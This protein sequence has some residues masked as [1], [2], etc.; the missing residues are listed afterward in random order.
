MSFL[1]N[2]FKLALS[3]GTIVLV[4]ALHKARCVHVIARFQAF[5]SPNLEFWNSN[6]NAKNFRVLER[7]SFKFDPSKARRARNRAKANP[8]NKNDS[9]VT[10]VKDLANLSFEPTSQPGDNLGFELQ[11][12]MAKALNVPIPRR[13]PPPAA[14]GSLEYDAILYLKGLPFS[15]TEADVV[16]W[17]SNYKLLHIVLIRDRDG[18]FTGD[19]YVRCKDRE[20]RDSIYIEMQHKI[21][22]TRYVQ[23]FRTTE[24][25]YN[26]YYKCGFRPEPAKRNY[27]SPKVLVVRNDDVVDTQ[28]QNVKHLKS[29]ASITG[30]IVEIYRNG[31][32]VDCNVYDIV[33]GIKERVLCVL[34]R[35]R[36]AKNI[37]LKGQQQSWLK[38]KELVLY[39]GLKVNLYVEKIRKTSA[40]SAFDEDLWLEHFSPELLLE[41]Y[42]HVQSHDGFYSA[43]QISPDPTGSSPE[44][45]GDHLKVNGP[46]VDLEKEPKKTF[47]ANSLINTL[48]VP[49]GSKGLYSM[50]YLTMDSSVTDDKVLWW[51]RK[52]LES[53]SKDRQ[54]KMDPLDLKLQFDART[55]AWIGGKPKVNK[56]DVVVKSRKNYAN[57]K[58]T[59]KLHK[60]VSDHANE[61]EENTPQENANFSLNDKSALNDIDSYQE[62][63]DRFFEGSEEVKSEMHGFDGE[64]CFQMD[65]GDDDLDIRGDSLDV[66]K[67]FHEFISADQAKVYDEL[68][69][70]PRT[71]LY[72]PAIE[73]PGY[74]LILRQSQVPGLTDVQVAQTLQLFNIKPSQGP[75][76]A[77]ENRRVLIDTIRTKGLGSDLD[78][79]T[80]IKKGLYKVN[81]SKRKMKS[82]IKLTKPLTGRR[83]SQ[84]DLDAASKEELQMLAKEGLNKFFNWDPPQ[85]VK[86]Q[87]IQNFRHLIGDEEITQDQIDRAWYNLKYTMVINLYGKQSDLEEIIKALEQSN[88]IFK[89][90][91]EQAKTMFDV[92]TLLK[93]SGCQ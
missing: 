26:E 6:L 15:A 33:D 5:Q 40:R 72:D 93:L 18:Y 7:S 28:I 66:S 19:C 53:H 77:K 24:S 64:P 30:T 42:P 13:L 1:S 46:D 54:L 58:V 44:N 35:N 20:E 61:S 92:D 3:Y 84:E 21:M 23:I 56:K 86:V 38:D 81:Q 70:F 52:L 34:K 2:I 83:F 63:L 59:P 78:P 49:S 67:I 31:A 17:L 51:E 89:V 48:E 43:Q 69:A 60:I 11:A 47:D 4:I 36:I 82:I 16:N 45:P 73:L 50:V 91:P 12:F 27:M 74:G 88:K 71:T 39:P 80:L 65:S 57:A 62:S 9:I 8:K 79:L 32:L 87:F 29:G 14:P 75:E 41:L 85:A 10:S 76:S 90:D 55:S 68:K 25:A 22:G 37:G